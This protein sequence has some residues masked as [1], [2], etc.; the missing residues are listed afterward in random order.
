MKQKEH[1]KENCLNESSCLVNGEVKVDDSD[2]PAFGANRS[3]FERE[4]NNKLTSEEELDRIYMELKDRFYKLSCAL[5]KDQPS[6]TGNYDLSCKTKPTKDELV[7]ALN[8]W[9]CAIITAFRGS[10]KLS[11]EANLKRNE[12]LKTK[13]LEMGLLFRPV[14]GYYLG[15]DENHTS[16]K[17]I[18]VNE[19]SFF[20]TNTNDDGALRMD[21]AA[22]KDFFTKLFRLAEHYEQDS[23]LFTFPVAN[24][25][26]FRVATNSNGR[27]YFRNDIKYAG[28]LYTNIENIG[29]W[30][31]C[32]NDGKIAFMLKGMILKRV[33]EHELVWIG[34]GDIF[35]IEHYN[36]DSLVIIHDNKHAELNGS[37]AGYKKDH[38]N[39][40]EYVF[41]NEAIS[42]EDIRITVIKMLETLPN[43]SR[44]IGFHCSASLDGSYME[45]AKVAYDTILK[46]V[47]KNWERVSKIVIVDIYGDYCKI[48]N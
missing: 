26:A 9:N 22:R 46:W 14:D 11:E 29:A 3:L 31:G 16:I 17:R 8:K 34:E 18:P 13:M 30:T 23:F 7:D 10:G 32:A 4:S 48:Q 35:D 1:I 37:C 47:E 45:G 20:V 5:E 2:T 33:Y 27:S 24:G 44:T 38:D 41:V 43:N 6:M 19:Y 12:E 28:R 42:E 40:Y 39:L 21:E 25:V 36:P 15:I